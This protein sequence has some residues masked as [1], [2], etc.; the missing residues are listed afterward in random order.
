MVEVSDLFVVSL[1]GIRFGLGWRTCLVG[2]RG[3]SWACGVMAV[4][5]LAVEVAGDYLTIRPAVASLVLEDVEGQEALVDF[6]VVVVRRTL[7]S[8]FACMQEGFRVHHHVLVVMTSVEVDGVV[9]AHFGNRRKLDR[10]RWIET[11]LGEY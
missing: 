6:A 1:E 7:G 11:F 4:F 8:P 9:A 2:V 3:Y 5:V 10:Q